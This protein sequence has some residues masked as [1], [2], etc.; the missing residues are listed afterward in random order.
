MKK[1]KAIVLILVFILSIIFPLTI[2]ATEYQIN[3]EDFH[4]E[5]P[6]TDDVKEMYKFG[7]S[8]AAVIQI[9]GTMVSVG[10]IIIIGIKYVLASAEEKAEYKE[11][12]L[13]FVI[14]CVLLFGSSTIVNILYKV[15][16][17]N[18]YVHSEEWNEDGKMYEVQCINQ[19]K[20]GPIQQQCGATISLAI[21]RHNDY[22]C[23]ACGAVLYEA[24]KDAPT[25]KARVIKITSMN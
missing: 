11:K 1:S 16:D 12:M 2:N 9:V 7:G 18:I 17:M 5:G 22:K 25:S 24:Y 8:V 19:V 13:P 6:E 4:S 3:A 23:S 21:P 20:K 10:G 14:G 15:S